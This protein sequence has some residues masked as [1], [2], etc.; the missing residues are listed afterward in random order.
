MK[1]FLTHGY[2]WMGIAVVMLLIWHPWAAAKK[3]AP[4]PEAA[5]TDA[6][7]TDT[8]TTAL[9]NPDDSM[10]QREF[11]NCLAVGYVR[12]LEQE[13]IQL[14]GTVAKIALDQSQLVK[15]VASTNEVAT[16]ALAEV[17]KAQAEAQTKASSSSTTDIQ[18]ARFEE[19]V[20]YPMPGPCPPWPSYPPHYPCPL[21][22]EGGDWIT[23][24]GEL[25]LVDDSWSHKL[26]LDDR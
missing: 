18:R 2:T 16:K 26:G 11:I 19:Y 6:V 8:A 22:G 3:Q 24:D 15:A 10:S 13:N 1:K 20:Q 21:M 25:V 14:Q 9:P 12:H 5:T 23:V 7:V 17:A 4:E